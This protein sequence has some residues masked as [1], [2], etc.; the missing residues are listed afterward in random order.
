LSSNVNGLSS[1]GTSFSVELADSILSGCVSVQDVQSSE[2][3][4]FNDAIEVKAGKGIFVNINDCSENDVK[5]LS[6]DGKVLLN[7]EVP[8]T[9]NL[10]PKVIYI[11]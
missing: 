9:Y 3:T 4:L 6:D 2:F 10:E 1:E 8:T 5:F 7:K 11:L